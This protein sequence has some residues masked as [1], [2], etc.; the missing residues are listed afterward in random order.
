MK[1]VFKILTIILLSL[2]LICYFNINT[3]AINE[4]IENGNTNT[5]T[6][7]EISNANIDLNDD[8]NSNEVIE[9]RSINTYSLERTKA[10]GIYKIAI[11][12]DSNKALEVAGSNTG[13]NA[14]K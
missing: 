1:S 11:G 14:I 12:A 4:I 5:D 8:E 2:I 13:N 7:N 10:D 6:D 3:Y 9:T